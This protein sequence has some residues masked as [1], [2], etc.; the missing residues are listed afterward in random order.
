MSNKDGKSAADQGFDH[1][2]DP[3]NQQGNAD[4]EERNQH[5]AFES[6]QDSQ[7]GGVSLDEHDRESTTL[8]PYGYGQHV[9]APEE[10]PGPASPDDM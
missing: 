7:D 4:S 3:E 6:D 5:V 10:V 1:E 2:S 8:T 9:F